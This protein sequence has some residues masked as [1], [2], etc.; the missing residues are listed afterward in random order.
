MDKIM[1]IRGLTVKT[2]KKVILNHLDLDIFSKSVNT[3]VGPSGGGKSTLLRVLNRLVD[4]D[5][6]LTVSGQVIFDGKNILDYDESELRRQVGMVFQKPNPFPMSVYEN[7]A[8]GLRILG[9]VPKQKMDILVREALEEA[10]L[11]DEVKDNLKQAGTTLSGGQQQRLCIARALVLRP[12]VL[13]MDEPTSALDPIAKGKI[14]DLMKDLKEKYTVI[15][16]THDMHQ[17]QRVSD[18][19]SLIFNGKITLSTDNTGFLDTDNKHMKRF[20]GEGVTGDYDDYSE[21]DDGDA[22]P[23]ETVEP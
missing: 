19:G 23:S 3:I 18:V 22:N 2:K 14:E 5:P 10:G 11:Y 16:V 17:A 1:E 7:V 20:L 13:M 4:N 8:F 12:K 6:T 15:L 9:N 21:E